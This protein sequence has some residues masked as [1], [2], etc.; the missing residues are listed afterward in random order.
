MPPE[1]RI[2]TVCARI[3][4]VGRCAVFLLVAG[5]TLSS[6]ADDIVVNNQTGDDRNSGDVSV[7]GSRGLQG[8]QNGPVRSIRR[9]LELAKPGDRIIV[10][11]TDVAYSESLS[12]QGSRHSGT[13]L[14]DF[15]IVSNGAIL[16]GRR[17][18]GDRWEL[19]GGDLYEFVPERKSHQILYID[20]LPVPMTRLEDDQSLANLEPDSW[21]LRGGRI[22]LRTDG[23]HAN[24]YATS[25]CFLPVGITLYQTH[26]VVIDGL[27]IQGFQLDGINAHDGVRQTTVSG[28]TLRGNGRSGISVGGSS[29]LHIHSCLV[30]NNQETQ[31]RTEQYAVSQVEDCDILGPGTSELAFGSRPEATITPVLNSQDDG[32]E[33]PQ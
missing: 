21:T 18:V 17:P 28:C 27:I 29:Q 15:V 20:D 2:V 22:Y 33:L 4:S 12:I 25:Y 31:L 5:L 1:E 8:S 13:I 6:A 11:K 10:E 16:D 7:E 30:G 24:R 9:A 19:V 23:R 26:N 32:I 14:G 3:K